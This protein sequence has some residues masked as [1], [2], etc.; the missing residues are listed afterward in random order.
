MCI[1][2]ATKQTAGRD[3]FILIYLCEL[4]FIQAKANRQMRTKRRSGTGTLYA[5][6]NMWW[7]GLMRNGK[8]FRMSLGIHVNEDGEN[9][10]SLKNLALQKLKE[11]TA[12]FRLEREQDMLLLI[13]AKLNENRNSMAE[14]KS[15]KTRVRLDALYQL[16]EASKRRRQVKPERLYQYRL[17]CDDLVSF[18]GMD[19]LVCNIGKN[20]AEEY[21]SRMEDESKFSATT[22]N[23]KVAALNYMW[24]VLSDKIGV[25]PE[26][27]PWAS[28]SKRVGKSKSHAVFTDSQIEMLKKTSVGRVNGDLRRMILIGSNTG[29]RIS[30]CCCLDWREVYLEE[31]FIRRD[32]IKTGE[33]VSVPILS[34]LRKELNKM[35]LEQGGHPSGKILPSMYAKYIN[36]H[37]YPSSAFRKLMVKCGIGM[38]D[39]CGQG[40]DMMLSFHSFRA[41]AATKFIEAG[42]PI[43]IVRTILGH[44]A[45]RMTRHYVQVRENAIKEAF[46]KAN[47]K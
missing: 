44:T 33:N 16:F 10:A 38:F 5:R 43:E 17:I 20:E 23:L 28:I 13:K 6:G 12:L 21:V 8:I 22:I 35:R 25:S 47:V 27:N 4:P 32:T 45:D 3:K 37:Q 1:I 9:P 39:N 31:G 40:N 7:G 19:F 34:E 24:N 41:T 46:R 2:T 42:I 30:D 36:N 14:L 18:K 11:E 26:N 15:I 29:L